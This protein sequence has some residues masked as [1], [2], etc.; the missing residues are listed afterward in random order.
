M[1]ATIVEVELLQVDLPPRVP[2]SDAIQ[3]FVTQETPM[4]RIRCDDGTDDDRSDHAR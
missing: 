2:R 1:S 3:S 4:V